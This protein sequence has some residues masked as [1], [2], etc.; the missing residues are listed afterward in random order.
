MKR[1]RPGAKRREAA[2]PASRAADG[3]EATR[4]LP[5]ELTGE[6]AGRRRFVTPAGEWVAWV[7]GRGVGGTGSY[8]LAL[9]EAVR[10]ARVEQPDR[11]VSEVLVGRGTFDRSGEDELVQLLTR[12]QP[13]DT[14][15]G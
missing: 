3:A 8:G 9:L 1:V 11:P 10:F 5:R 4:H 6:P 12:A 7:A 2:P 13:L 14:G 15:G